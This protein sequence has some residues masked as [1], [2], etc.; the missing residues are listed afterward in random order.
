MHRPGHR[1][2]LDTIGERLFPAQAQEGL[3]SP[4][5]VAHAQ[6]SGMLALGAGLLAAS[7]PS[8]QRTSFGQALGQS[9]QGAQQGV[10]ASLDQQ[11]ERRMALQKFQEQQA[12]TQRRELL[13]RERQRIAQQYPMPQE[14]GNDRLMRWVEQVYPKFVELGDD[15]MISRLTQVAS[16]IGARHNGATS[17]KIDE[18]IDPTT[19]KPAFGH[20]T[21]SGVQ[22]IPGATPVQKTGTQARARIQTL[23]NPATGKPEIAL[24]DPTTN[25]FEFTGQ[26]PGSSRDAAGTEGERKGAVLMTLALD[27]APILDQAD[28]PSRIE[29]LFRAGGLREA[30]SAERQVYDQ[31]GLVIADAYIRLTSGANAPEPEVQRTKK[32][33]TPEPGDSPQLI[34]RKRA[35]RQAL[36]KALSIAAGRASA[37]VIEPRQPGESVDDYMKRTGRA[38]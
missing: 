7:G 1:G 19:G 36:I 27:A 23:V 9:I 6:R 11:I 34:A 10:Q 3:I 17:Q 22:I 26:V 21:P 29:Q 35:T 38:K 12:A 4:E 18:V 16:S 14:G 8:T 28:A 2:L 31:A 15:E 13:Q 24:F 20:I 5:D 30:L 32:M 25:Q 33:I 37:Q